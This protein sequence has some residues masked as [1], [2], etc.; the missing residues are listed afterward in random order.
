MGIDSALAGLTGLTPT[1]IYQSNGTTVTAGTFWN[2][3]LAPM[4]DY[5][6]PMVLE[7]KPGF[8]R[9]GFK[10][11]YGYSVIAFNAK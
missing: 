8:N 4:V 10:S 5:R 7:T 9:E 6:K 1:K 3:T 2:T 11:N